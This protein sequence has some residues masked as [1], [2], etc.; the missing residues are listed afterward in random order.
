MVM[1]RKTGGSAGKRVWGAEMSK[2]CGR[3]ARVARPA[4]IFAVAALAGLVLATASASAAVPASMTVEAMLSSSGGGAV[5]DGNYA[6]TFL[7][8]KDAE[9]GSAYWSE[10]PAQVA[11]K[12]GALSYVLGTTTPLTASAVAAGAWVAIKVGADPEMQRRL[13]R[14]VPYALRAG[15]AEGL[16]CSG[17][18]TV[19]MINSEVLAGYAKTADLSAYAKATDLGVY[20]KATDLAAYTPTTKLAKVA[21]TGA[22]AD[23]SGL[24]TLA[25][26]GVACG[27]G[28]AVKGI[29]ADGSLDCAASV[30]GGKC[31]AGQVVIEVTADGAVVCGSPT[32]AGGACAPGKLVSEVKVDGTVSCVEPEHAPWLADKT[33][34]MIGKVLSMNWT[35]L[36]QVVSVLT[37]T[38]YVVDV[39]AAGTN[40]GL[41]QNVTGGP[42]FKSTDCT[43]SPWAF[44]GIGPTFSSRVF[45]RIAPL[46]Q[47]YIPVDD[48]GGLTE[49]FGSY[50]F[51]AICKTSAHSGFAVE[52][53][54]ATR[55]DIGLPVIMS[56]PA[57]IKQ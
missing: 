17:C 44:L 49:V 48:T 36:G 16:D 13:L 5:A 18:V 28:L 32:I 3:L 7:L 11:V 40:A 8:Y 1:T 25:K 12:N 20:A 24:P 51:G 52:L 27:T 43:G 41:T 22:Y 6:M 4:G 15:V 42:Y 47:V 57:T 23:L 14:S 34:K 56:F 30:V 39:I 29:K 33:G 55:A 2:V 46:E 54:T 9:G 45:V 38:G 37:S 10:G 50:L 26:V 31:A 19:G 35:N 21:T 53:K